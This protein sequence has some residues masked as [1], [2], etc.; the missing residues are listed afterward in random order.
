MGR[1]WKLDIM[2][3]PCTRHPQ[4]S[5]PTY[6]PAPLALK[7]LGSDCQD[8]YMCGVWRNQGL[9]QA[10]ERVGSCMIHPTRPARYAYVDTAFTPMDAT[11]G[12][13]LFLMTAVILSSTGP[14]TGWVEGRLQGDAGQSAQTRSICWCSGWG[15]KLRG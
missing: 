4:S 6:G 2:K 8:S 3:P 15:I 10:P 9:S 12:N 13:A 14:L 1:C 7:Q 11:M 5:S